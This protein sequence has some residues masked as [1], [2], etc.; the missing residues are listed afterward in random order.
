MA[1]AVA[2]I[3]GGAVVNAFYGGYGAFTGGGG[4]VTFYFQN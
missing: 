3:I 4:G 1:S 2:M